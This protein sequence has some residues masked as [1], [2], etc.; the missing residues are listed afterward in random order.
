VAS[1]QEVGGYTHAKISNKLI[2]TKH[3]ANIERLVGFITVYSNS[4]DS[5]KGRY[6]GYR[7]VAHFGD[8]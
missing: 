8:N 7:V 6:Y 4:D 1:L 2:F 3:S 5:L